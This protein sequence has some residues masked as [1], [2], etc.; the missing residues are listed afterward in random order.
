MI[1]SGNHGEGRMKCGVCKSEIN[2]PVRI[3]GQSHCPYCGCILTNGVVKLEDE[4]HTYAQVELPSKSTADLT[5]EIITKLGE[6]PNDPYWEAITQDILE[7]ERWMW[8]EAHLGIDIKIKYIEGLLT[9]EDILKMAVN[10]G[11]E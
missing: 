2:N 7:N 1:K 8:I 5:R 11:E 4:I 9:W 3:S 10:H 6:D